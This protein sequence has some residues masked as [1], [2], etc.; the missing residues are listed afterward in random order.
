MTGFLDLR[1][2]R[3]RNNASENST[4]ED[5][6][7][8]KE[9]QTIIAKAGKL[10]QK[11]NL[12][13]WAN[14]FRLLRRAESP[15]TIQSVLNWYAHH[16]GKKG[17]SYAHSAGS[18]RGK[19]KKLLAQMGT[20]KQVTTID[21]PPKVK[22]AARRLQEK[23]HRLRWPENTKPETWDRFILET[24]FFLHDFRSRI[25]RWLRD[26]PEHQ[27]TPLMSYVL[28]AAP[29]YNGNWLS[30]YLE[31]VNNM[32]WHWEPWNGSFP[33]SSLDNHRFDKELH[34]LCQRFTGKP[35]AWRK[36]QGIVYAS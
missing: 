29:Q 23:C 24:V 21:P 32:A 8:A 4:E 9:L 33:V 15:E 17:V 1:P 18:F 7:M 10:H 11:P 13:R 14:E 27:L 3:P 31:E 25:A 30:W 12:A 6:R 34:D 19:F 35:D 2:F 26:N 36:V 22:E 5:H 28:E 16:I 20:H